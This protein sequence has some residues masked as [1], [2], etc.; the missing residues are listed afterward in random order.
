VAIPPPS[1]PP[2][3]ELMD[4]LAEVARSD[5]VTWA[6]HQQVRS[7]DALWWAA[8]STVVRV[9]SWEVTMRKWVVRAALGLG[10]VLVLAVVVLPWVFF[11]C[12]RV[13]VR[14]TS[15]AF[16]HLAIPTSHPP[17]L[18]TSLNTSKLAGTHNRWG[19]WATPS[20]CLAY[21]V[22]TLALRNA[23]VSSA[24]RSRKQR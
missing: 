16:P 22:A 23:C 21:R 7:I 20:R 18:T 10:L 14:R 5:R 6:W 19:G 1:F 11:G 2:R 8:R 12:P 13:R 24:C 3:A 9:S 17:T 15:P 4:A